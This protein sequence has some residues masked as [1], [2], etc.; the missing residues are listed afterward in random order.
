[1]AGGVWSDVDFT[2]YAS[3]RFT[4]FYQG[5]LHVAWV[6]TMGDDALYHSVSTSYNSSDGAHRNLFGRIK[7]SGRYI[8]AAFKMSW[9]FNAAETVT[10]GNVYVMEILGYN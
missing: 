1:M 8:E 4:L 6:R 5:Q 2:K 9:N 3:L 10:A 7:F